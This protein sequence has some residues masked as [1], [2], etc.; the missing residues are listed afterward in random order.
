[1]SNGKVSIDDIMREMGDSAD[2]GSSPRL[3]AIAGLAQKLGELERKSKTLDSRVEYLTKEAD[4]MKRKSMNLI[5]RAYNKGVRVALDSK[6]P[7]GLRTVRFSE[8][9]VD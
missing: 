9:G 5:D 2:R 6:K 7:V 8:Y 3:D 1:M 4:T